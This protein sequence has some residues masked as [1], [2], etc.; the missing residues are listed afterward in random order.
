[1]M[2]FQQQM[3]FMQKFAEHFQP[4]L[5]ENESAKPSHGNDDECEPP[6]T[7]SKPDQSRDK[8]EENDLLD[9]IISE[10]GTGDDPEND[11]S[12]INQLL[13][14]MT[15]FYNDSE[16]TSGGNRKIF[17]ENN[18]FFSTITHRRRKVQRT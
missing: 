5:R 7:Q 17:G 15:E 16:E 6:C 14:E 10:I 11:I 1:M 2:A 8:D 13:D 9:N 4:K 18:T 12:E 3:E